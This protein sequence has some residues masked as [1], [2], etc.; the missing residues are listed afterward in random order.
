MIKFS[1][2]NM[3]MKVLSNTLPH[4]HYFSG[5][6]SL[7]NIL[8]ISDKYSFLKEVIEMDIPKEI[9]QKTRFTMERIQKRK[10][11]A[12]DWAEYTLSNGEF[13]LSKAILPL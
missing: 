3:M 1:Q 12:T 13:Y 7:E 2:N 6:L 9:L 5:I 10:T 8:S 4:F 11:Q